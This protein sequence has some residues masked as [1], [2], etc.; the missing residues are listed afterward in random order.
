[1]AR[2]GKSFTNEEVQ[3]IINLLSLTDMT[4]P[5]IAARMHC[6]RSGVATINRKF[7]VREYGGLRAS[8]NQR[9]HEEQRSA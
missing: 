3:R 7:R 5:E 1:M 9:L 6:S 4:I 2:Q 8:W